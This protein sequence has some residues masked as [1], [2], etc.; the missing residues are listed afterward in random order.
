MKSI[1]SLYKKG[2]GPS[3]SHSMG[4]RKAAELFKEK[5][6]VSVDGIT[7][8]LYGSLAATGKG[9]LTDKAISDALSGYGVT[10]IWKPQHDLPLYSN[11][12]IF[13]AYINGKRVKSWT[14]Y[15]IGGGEIRDGN[16]TIDNRVDRIYNTDCITPILS[17][18]QISKQSLIEYIGAKEDG[19]F[20][21]HMES[22]WTSMKSAVQRGLDAKDDYLPGPLKLKRRAQSIFRS[23]NKHIGTIRDMNLV[24][25][26]ALA[27]AEENADGG[28]IVTAPTCGSCGVLPGILYFLYHDCH[29]A[30]QDAVKAMA[31]GGLFGV[32]VV[33][34]ASISGAEVGCQGEVGT[35]CAMASAATAHLLGGTNEQIEYAAE[36]GLE[37]FLGLTCDPV[38]GFV[39]IPCIERNA[40]ASMRALECASFAVSTDGRHIVS[41]DDVVSVM[42][43]TGRD[44]QRKYRETSLGGLAGILA[45]KF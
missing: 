44:L 32:S 34:R 40:F 42:N 22:T 29:M 10:F 39:Q 11:G 5:L 27:V 2:V 31:V 24:S 43:E 1:L 35:A 41:F 15:S 3:S 30:D 25:A 6:D 9:H 14:V 17:E 20:L 13:N 26:Y 4:P 18:C 28:Q 19:A 36:M 16:E 23:A 7:V 8:E 21:S 38:K 33:S 12:M 37:H 45:N